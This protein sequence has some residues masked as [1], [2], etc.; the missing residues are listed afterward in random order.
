VLNH[1]QYD[2]THSI[3]PHALDIVAHTQYCPMHSIF[4][5]ALDVVAHTQY[6][7]QH[8]NPFMCC[9]CCS[10]VVR[11]DSTGHSLDGQEG[12]L[13]SSVPELIGQLHYEVAFGSTKHVFSCAQLTRK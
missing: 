11:V 8:L 1:T 12:K 3:L 6:C 9:T 4:C 10:Y 2:P 7:L 5:G 13:V